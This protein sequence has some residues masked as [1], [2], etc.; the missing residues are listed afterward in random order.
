M[1]HYI[2]HKVKSHK[3]IEQH[4]AAAHKSGVKFAFYFDLLNTVR[5]FYLDKIEGSTDT[6]K[7]K[8]FVVCNRVRALERQT[9]KQ[10]QKR[11][12]KLKI[13]LAKKGIEYKEDKN[14][15]VVKSDYYLNVFS[16]SS[17]RN[18]RLNIKNTIVFSEKIGEFDSYGL[19]KEGATIP[20]F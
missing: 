9:P 6:P 18:F 12:E 17:Q 16:C 10:Q 1:K 20:L 4:L 11:I 19:S 15:R 7:T 5:F 14:K 13:H 8:Q 3:E 2:E